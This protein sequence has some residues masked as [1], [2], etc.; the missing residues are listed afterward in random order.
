MGAAAGG[1]ICAGLQIDQLVVLRP[2]PRRLRR[3]TGWHQPAWWVRC[4]CGQVVLRLQ[5]SVLRSIEAGRGCCNACRNR[6][7]GQSLWR[8]LLRSQWAEH[9]SLYEPSAVDAIVDDV[10][11]EVSLQCGEILESVPSAEELRRGQRGEVM[12]L[13]ALGSYR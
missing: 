4:A 12:Q 7:V 9:R 10:R 13:P 11:D 8:R 6:R 2:G 3:T 1:G 5:E